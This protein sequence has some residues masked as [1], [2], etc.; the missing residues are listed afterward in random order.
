MDMKKYLKQHINTSEKKFKLIFNSIIMKQTSCL[1]VPGILFLLLLF[2]ISVFGQT[3]T[4]QGTV[5]DASNA[6]LMGVSIKVQGSSIGTITDLDGKYSIKVPSSSKLIFS[7][8]GYKPQTINVD[9]KGTINIVLEEDSKVLEEV[10]AIGYGTVRKS[11][12]TGS[13]SSVKP[14]A[15]MA[16]APTNLQQALQGKVAGMIVTQNGSGVNT[17]P[18]IRLR[19]NRSIGASNDPLFVIDG[20]PTNDGTN[21]INP[22]DVQSIEVLKDASATAIYGARGANG[23]ILVTTKRGEKG[24]ITVEYNGDFSVGQ[25]ARM[26]KM[27]TGEQYMEYQRDLSRLYTYDGEGG[28]TLRTDAGYGSATPNYAKDIALTWTQDPYIS[29]SLKLAWA[30]GTYNPAKLRTFNWQMDGIN[31]NPI[32]QTHNLSI[33]A[34]SE[35]TQI[36]VSG[37]FIDQTGST[38]QEFQKKYTLRMNIDQKLGDR[39]TMGGS[40]N[41]SDRDWDGGQWMASYWNPLGTPWYSKDGDVTNDGDPAYGVIPQPCGDGL[42][43]SNYMDLTGAKRQNRN[44][45]VGVN[46]YASLKLLK[47]LTYKATVGEVLNLT[48]YNKF[49]AKYTSTIAVTGNAKASKET[50]VSRSWTFEN[51]LSYNT[52]IEDHSLGLTLVQSN[53]KSIWDQTVATGVGIPIETQLWNALGNASVSQATTSAFTQWQLQSYVGRVNYSYKDRYLL[54]GTLRYDGSSRLAEGHKWVAFPSVALGWRVT[55]ESF[56]KDQTWLD[57]LKIRAGYG[58]TGNSSVSAYSTVGQITSSRYNWSNTSLAAGYLPNTLSND[59]LTWE[60][61][62]QYDVGFDLS[63]LGGRV[64]ASFDWYLQNTSDLLMSR[65]LPS[66]SGFT[67]ITSNIGS[68]KNQGFEVS[69]TTENIKTKDFSWETTLNFATNKE[70]IT[71][72]NTG[73]AYDIDN[74]WFVGHPVD[75]YYDYVA[76]PTVWGYSKEDFE[77]MAK[78]NANGSSYAPG[79]LRLVDLNGDYK[80]TAADDR[81]IRGSKMPKWTASMANTFTYGPFDLYIFMNTAIGSTIYYDSGNVSDGKLNITQALANSYWTPTRTNTQYIAPTGS[82]APSTISASYFWKGDYL[83]INDITLGYTIDKN[84]FLKDVGIQKVRITLKCLNP[85]LFTKFPGID[86]EGAIAQQRYYGSLNSFSDAGLLLRTYKVGL[87]VTF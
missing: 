5:K 72:L 26:R 40:V 30:D 46:F 25:I 60:K 41:F 6:A 57:N 59:A 79:Q 62:G 36:F 48:Q 56:M 42:L 39:I 77:E 17:D 74:K 1:K 4:V 18:V 15:L 35:K 85:V 73:L 55:E 63:V 21:M 65:S 69:L 13:V 24:K 83:K 19:G 64:S 31:P 50:Q 2:S 33:R 23:V 84:K 58:K 37:S 29:Q 80:I 28:Y 22:N 86:P 54:T 61:T 11:D 32:S 44:N 53:E 20:I 71:S 51:N 10:V 3:I 68:T 38:L 78:F 9:G 87:N 45:N 34:G 82:N 14:Q 70:E 67:S 7:Y 66:T 76:Y 81:Q 12:V 47:G 43:Y 49:Y 16:S 8:V 27:A 52:K 75:T